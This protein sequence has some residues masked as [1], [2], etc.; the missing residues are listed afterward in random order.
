[1]K[2]L[3]DSG[4]FSGR[5]LF[6]SFSFFLYLGRLLLLPFG[7]AACCSAFLPFGVFLGVHFPVFS[8]S[9]PLS[10]KLNAGSLLNENYYPV[11]R[12]R[13]RNS[14][15]NPGVALSR[16]ASHL[17]ALGA[18]YGSCMARFNHYKSIRSGVFYWTHDGLCCAKPHW[19]V[20][21]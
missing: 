10:E 16:H 17:R 3:L 20:V 18:F 19:N 4:V 7:S 9:L 11:T 8:G 5:V 2:I 21:P 6:L 14:S 15:G 13:D 12:S 1:M